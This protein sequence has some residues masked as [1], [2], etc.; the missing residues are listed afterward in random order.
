MNKRDATERER[1]S[2]M[3]SASG[4]LSLTTRN[5]KC[6]PF[7]LC[8]R[9]AGCA[10]QT[11]AE[12]EGEPVPRIP[13]TPL[14]CW[15]CRDLG[16][17]AGFW[18]TPGRSQTLAATDALDSHQRTTTRMRS[19]RAKTRYSEDAKQDTRK[20]HPRGTQHQDARSNATTRAINAL[21]KLDLQTYAA[22]V[23]NNTYATS[24]NAH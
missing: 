1:N 18:M 5:L 4:V 22:N 23:T 17:S 14:A 13:S 10:C 16:G 7:D 9:S 3:A 8:N 21:H 24:T 20:R 2:V 11:D 6:G 12:R 15:V 19:G